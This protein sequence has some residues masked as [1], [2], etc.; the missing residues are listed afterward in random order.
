MRRGDYSGSLFRLFRS[1]STLLISIC[2]LTPCV[3]Q[4]QN[5]IPLESLFD[6]AAVYTSEG[7]YANAEKVYTRILE[8]DPEHLQ[9]RVS[10]AHLRAWQKNYSAAQA[11]FLLVLVT[12]PNNSEALIGLGYNLIWA[13]DFEAGENRFLRL[14]NKSPDHPEAIKGMAWSSLWQDQPTE[15]VKWF[16]KLKAIGELDAASSAGL[17][18]A[19]HAT[20]KFRDARRMFRQAS[21]QGAADSEYENYLHQTTRRSPVVEL[22]IRGGS[23]QFE[24]ESFND[25][26]AIELGVWPGEDLRIWARYDNSLGADNLFFQQLN[27]VVPGYFLG[28]SNHFAPHLTSKLEMGVVDIPTGE[29][30]LIGSLEQVFFLGKSFTIKAGGI[31]ASA[32]QRKS[33]LAGYAGFGYSPNPKLFLE[34]L[35]YFSSFNERQDSDWRAVLNTS[36]DVHTLLKLSSSVVYGQITSVIPAAEGDIFSASLQTDLLLLHQ[37]WLYAQYR[38]ESTPLLDYQTISVGLKLRLE[39]N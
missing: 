1:V 4:A 20:G 21:S 29:E 3:L 16:E 11:D 33:D 35:M 19:Y 37:H 2:F 28:L 18:R 5:G 8:A 27:E 9:A 32:S 15:A 10:R 38:Y 7:D 14:L 34:P 25:L 24:N 23:S 22:D 30:L 26:R 39:R 36:F 6:Q 13:N 17:G 12:H 31:A